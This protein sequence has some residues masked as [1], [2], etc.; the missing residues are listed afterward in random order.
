[1]TAVVPNPPVPG[2]VGVVGASGYTGAEALR[3]LADHPCLSVAV[4]TADSQSGRLVG[5]VHP[6]LGPAYPELELSELDLET[7]DGLDV[8]FCCLPHGASST[9]VPELIG[10]VGLIADLGADFRF[11]SADVY[12]DWYGSPHDHPELL[13]SFGY[14]LPELFPNDLDKPHL[15]IPGC[16]PTAA[17]LALVPLA[18]DGLIETGSLI[19]DAASGISGAGRGPNEKNTF[20]AVD[21][22]YT[23][24]S[25]FSHRHTPEIEWSLQRT[26]ATGAS[27]LFTPH[28]APMSRGILATC[29]AR[30]DRTIGNAD[31]ADCLGRAYDSAP[32]VT[33][34][35][36][37]PGTKATLGSNAAHVMA[38]VDDRT[39]WVVALCAIDNLGKGASGQALQCVNR[40]LGID[41]TIGLT[42]VGV[43]P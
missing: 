31:L 33:V 40:K 2:R 10:R 12:P 17:S 6:A 7:L 27:V 34:T 11:D 37:L 9:L 26:G 5:E 28:L 14:G 41:E 1:M 23:A 19:V 20:G 18:R 38:R 25:L 24:Y 39:G 4:A 42:T 43:A 30:P 13:D 36:E 3:L 21:S 22:N 8:V 16:Y 15:A 32:F 35:P 29:Y